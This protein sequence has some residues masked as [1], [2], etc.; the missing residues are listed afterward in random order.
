MHAK[1]DTYLHTRCLTDSLPIVAEVDKGIVGALSLAA[2]LQVGGNDVV[3]DLDHLVVGEG[4]ADDLPERSVLVG[5][6]D[7]GDLVEF[8]ALL[9]DAEDAED[10]K[11]TRLNSIN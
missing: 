4:G 1:L 7:E 11:S 10:R 8:L 3:D 9:V 6:A 5:A 2:L